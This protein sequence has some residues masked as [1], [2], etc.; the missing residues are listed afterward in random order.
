MAVKRNVLIGMW[1]VLALVGCVSAADNEK[2]AADGNKAAIVVGT[3]DSRAVVVAYA[4]SEPWKQK[5]QQ[6]KKAQDE[7]KAAG[8][9]KKVEELEQWGLTQQ[10]KFHMQGFGTADV[11]DLLEYIRNDIP[12][13]AKEAG[14][15]IIVSKWDIAYQSPSAKTVDITEKIVAPFKPDE[16]LLVMIRDLM[17][18]APM[19]NEV[20]EKADHTKF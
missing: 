19:S 12:Q 4:H 7:A 8:D 1:A 5:L 15:D 14:V 9:T 17:T 16:K 10:K 11:N 3:F 6:M 2:A 18:K 20:L 13:I